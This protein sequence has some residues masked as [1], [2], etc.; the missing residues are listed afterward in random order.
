MSQNWP[1]LYPEILIQREKLSKRGGL[2]LVLLKIGAYREFSIE[3]LQ[4]ETNWRDSILR[5][6]TAF[7]SINDELKTFVFYTFT[8]LQLFQIS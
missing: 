2:I 7:N 8:F 6:C 1:Y 3:S 4:N 5:H